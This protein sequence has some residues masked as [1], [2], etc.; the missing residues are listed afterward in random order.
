MSLITDLDVEVF[1]VWLRKQ[2]ILA[3]DTETN[4]CDH[5]HLRF[6]VGVSFYVPGGEPWYL[7]VGHRSDFLPVENV[8]F[9]DFSKDLRPTAQLIFHNAKFDLKILKASGCDLFKFEIIDTMLWSHLINQYRPHSLAALEQKYLKKDVKKGLVQ[10][11]KAIRETYGMEAVPPIAMAKYA[12]NDVVSTF[13]LYEFF[14]PMMKK[15][16]LM[17]VWKTDEQ[18][19]KLLAQIETR[20][21]K[22]DRQRARLLAKESKA[23]I[24]TIQDHLPFDPAKSSQVIARFYS[25][26]PVGLG[27]KPLK[28]TPGGKPSTDDVALSVI[29][30]PEAG[31]VLEYRSLSKAL[32]TWYLGFLTKADQ[33]GYL[34]PY[35]KQHGTLTHRLSAENP[36][37]QQIPREGDVKSLFLPEEGCDLIEFDY[38]AIEFRLAAVYAD[39]PSLLKIFG[40][41]G[42]IHQAV[43]DQL[44]IPRYIAKQANFCILYGG[45]PNKIAE[46]ASIPISTAR[47]VY[48]N[49]REQYP[50]LFR[51]ADFCEQ[52]A[53]D[54]GY[55]KYWDGRR[56]VFQQTYEHRK[57]FNSIIQGGAFNIIKRSMLSLDREGYD[58]RNQV[59]DSIWLNLIKGSDLS[60][61][62]GI[63]EDWTVGQF[64]LKFTVESKVLHS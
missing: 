23:R 64:G 15:A 43:A 9:W 30:H 32:S 21:L 47:T 17:D 24:Q 29:N 34:H 35:F 3:I 20:G 63:M 59:H 16:E 33:G 25:V 12:E 11:I 58:I 14:L 42:D 28:L 55:V 52:R 46:T 54:R 5:D 40:D 60:P 4:I 44:A 38:R 19:M 49:Y 62:K 53:R 13:E 61:I 56:R 45:G 31:L 2:S 41:D 27:L 39:N 22:L 6:L 7:P 36:N 18:F 57:A 51:V 48:Q 1:R 50:E 10:Q 37:P 26:P 8:S